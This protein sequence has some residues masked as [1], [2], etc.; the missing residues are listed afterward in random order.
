VKLQVVTALA[1]LQN[2]LL[3]A[4]SNTPNSLNYYLSEY[5]GKNYVNAEK[6]KAKSS[7]L[8]YGK[9]G[10]TFRRLLLISLLA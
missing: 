7:V 3:P 10:S 9:T 4:E 8:S 6:R 5:D 2:A 1:P